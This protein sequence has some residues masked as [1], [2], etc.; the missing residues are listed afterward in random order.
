MINRVGLVFS[1]AA[2]LV[3]YHFVSR[4]SVW[5]GST[6]AIGTAT[7]VSLG[8]RPIGGQPKLPRSDTTRRR[9]SRTFSG[10]PAGDYYAAK[11]VGRWGSYAT[12]PHVAGAQHVDVGDL[13]NGRPNFTEVAKGASAGIGETIETPYLHEGKNGE[14]VLS[15]RRRSI[16]GTRAKT[17]RVPLPVRAASA[18]TWLAVVHAAARGEQGSHTLYPA[19]TPIYS[20]GS[21]GPRTYVSRAQQGAHVG[22]TKR[23]RI[24]ILSKRA[25]PNNLSQRP[26][27]ARH[28]SKWRKPYGLLGKN[29]VRRQRKSR[30]RRVNP[31]RKRAW[32]N[33]VFNSSIQR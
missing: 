13:T 22:S 4:G 8:T 16:N 10:A 6:N 12:D 17:G 25:A 14:V 21:G 33:K 2:G 3:A 11:T 32:I 28:R 15:G 1:F 23:P 27:F 19:V 31:Q 24:R 18:R 7:S 29:N 20:S 9:K 30:I 5:V 26:K